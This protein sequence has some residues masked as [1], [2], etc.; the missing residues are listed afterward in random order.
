MRRSVIVAWK[1]G[2][3]PCN[4]WGL[5]EAFDRTIACR[6]SSVSRVEVVDAIEEVYCTLS[7]EADEISAE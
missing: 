5:E 3:V 2:D 6:G 4:G 7:L 1:I